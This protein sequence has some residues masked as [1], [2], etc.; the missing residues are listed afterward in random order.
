ML[1]KLILYALFFYSISNYI[2]FFTWYLSM[3]SKFTHEALQ[4]SISSFLPMFIFIFLTHY[5]YYPKRNDDYALVI[6][7]PPLVLLF[8]INLGFTISTLNLYHFQ[9]YSLPDSL[10]ILR[11]MEIGIVFIILAFAILFLSINEFRKVNEDPIPTSS[12]TLIIQ[13]G[14]YQY[15][16]NP[17]Y[18][19][20]LLL[21]LGIG[22]SLSMIHIILL[23]PLTFIILNYYVIVPEEEYLKIKFNDRYLKYNKKVRRWI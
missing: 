4:L 12:T 19:A 2:E 13:N 21:Q 7:F 20:M 18:L 11:S 15:T 23:I 9:L 5:L 16:R 3:E 10:N 22:M 14:I 8:C 1:N 17:M 6:S